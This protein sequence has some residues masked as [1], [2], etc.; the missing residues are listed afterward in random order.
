MNSSLRAAGGILLAAAV[1]ASFCRA[2]QPGGY[3]PEIP[4]Y[5]VVLKQ[6]MRD[7][8]IC[9]VDDGYYYLTGTTGADLWTKNAGI[10]LWR[11]RDLIDW[12]GLGLVWSIERDG[13]WQKQWTTKQGAPGEKPVRRRVVWAPEIHFLKGTF[14]IAYCM[15]GLGLGLLKSSTGKPTGPYVNAF[16]ADTPLCPG[17]IDASLF[18]DDDGT[19]YLL[20]GAGFIARLKPDRSGLAETPRQLRPTPPDLDPAN[21]SK[22]HCGKDHFNHVG[23]EGPFMFKTNGRYYL[24]CADSSHG[25][26]TC[27]AANAAAIYGPYGPRS[28]ALPWAGHVTVFQDFTGQWRSTFFDSRPGS[29]DRERAAIFR[30]GVESDGRLRPEPAGGNSAVSPLR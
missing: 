19:D 11:S 23:F 9:A 17:Q 29:R 5:R 12:E 14:W 24:L 18:E 26:Y 3:P 2:A 30:I 1:G 15:P 21:H 22:L 16:S 4:A 10:E 6:R 7:P 8:S 25:R 20:Y 13:T 27:M 28:E